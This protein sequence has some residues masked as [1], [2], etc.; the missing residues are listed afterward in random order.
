MI[1]KR[2]SVLLCWSSVR[3]A[4]ATPMDYKMAWTGEI[5]SKT[6]LVE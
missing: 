4:H 5:C 1:Y 3:D 6:N 2:I